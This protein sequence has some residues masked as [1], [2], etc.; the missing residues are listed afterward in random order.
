MVA[1]LC[2]PAPLADA[3]GISRVLEHGLQRILMAAKVLRRAVTKMSAN[4]LEIFTTS[5]GVPKAKIGAGYPS[6][7]RKR[8]RIR[9]HWPVLLF[10]KQGTELVTSTTENL[11]S[12]GF[13]CLTSIRFDPGEL[14][15]CAIRVPVYDPNGKAVDRNLECRVRIVRVEPQL[16][17]GTFGV[18]CSIEDYHF[19]ASSEAR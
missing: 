6:E 17:E 9:L 15:M 2:C 19:A 16:P 3:W 8:T 18:A 13:Y 11:S 5:V 14:L 1:G 10:R 12:T 7:R 4:P